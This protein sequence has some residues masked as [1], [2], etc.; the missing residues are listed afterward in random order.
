[1]VCVEGREKPR[2]GRC[3]VA[4][5][6]ATRL[7]SSIVSAASLL[8][9]SGHLHACPLSDNDSPPGAAVSRTLSTFSSSVPFSI[10]TY[11]Q[12]SDRLSYVFNMYSA[13]FPVSHYEDVT[14]S[15][16]SY[17]LFLIDPFFN[18]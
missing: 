1:M 5:S 16:Q 7:M 4:D 10:T 14:A 3:V 17:K 18:E 13:V 12:I 8:L 2:A 6:D 9:H 15:Q 11:E